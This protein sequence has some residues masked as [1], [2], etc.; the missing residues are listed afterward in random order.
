MTLLLAAA[1]AAALLAMSPVPS[2]GAGDEDVFQ[3][4]AYPNMFVVLERGASMTVNDNISVSDVDG[5]SSVNRY[6]LAL[7]VLFRVLNA[8][9]SQ[10][11]GHS[12]PPDRNLV[13][14]YSS[15]ID[16]DD[17]FFLSQ[18]VGFLSFDY[19][20]HSNSSVTAP[21]G[22]PFQVYAPG[23]P[24]NL[25]PYRNDNV[26]ASWQYRDLWDNIY[27]LGGP[28]TSGATIPIPWDNVRAC[29]S[30][31][32]S[33]DPD[34]CR[35]KV[36]VLIVT[37]EAFDTTG[38]WKTNLI[39]NTF[40]PFLLIVG[41][42]HRQDLRDLIRAASDIPDGRIAF[43]AGDADIENSTIFANLVAQ[44]Q[45]ST[46]EFVAPVVPAVRSTE[47]NRL[48]VA[49]FTPSTG[50]GE[51]RAFWPGHLVS[52]NLNTDGSIPSP[53]VANWDAA[54]R[55]NSRIAAR[56]IYTYE[57]SSG[58]RHEFHTVSTV[59]GSPPLVTRQM[60]GVTTDADR[61]IVVDSVRDLGLGDIFHS[62]PVLVGA[63][64]RFASDPRGLVARQTFVDTYSERKRILVAG[65]N[66]GMFH[67]F[68]AGNWNMSATPAGYDAGTGDEEWAYIPGFLVE[69]VKGFAP[70]PLGTPS[71]HNYY[72]DAP[73]TVTDIWV[74]SDTDITNAKRAEEWHT[75]AIGGA[76]RGGKGF[77]ALDITDPASSNYPAVLWE[78][79]SADSPYLGETWS[80]PAVG[81]LLIT[82]QITGTDVFYDKWVAL[83]GAG[84]A[85][86]SGR[87]QITSGVD[88][89]GGSVSG[90]T[91]TVDQDVGLAPASGG[92]TLT[93]GNRSVS[94]TYTSRSGNSFDN[95]T[96][97]AT[98]ASNKIVYPALESYVSWSATGSEGKA[99]LVL[100]AFTGSILQTLTHSSMGPVASSPTILNDEAG[101]IERGYI[102]D[103]QGNLWRVTVDNTGTFSLGGAP[104]ISITGSG[105]SNRIYTKPAVARGAGSYPYPW[106]YFGTGDRDAPMDTTSQGAIFGVFD[107]QFFTRRGTMTT[108]TISDTTDLTANST[109]LSSPDDQS[110]HLTVG[111][112]KKGWYA[113]LPNP[114]EK[115]L[116]S[117][118]A[119]FNGNLFFTT[120]Q[121]L[122]GN[123]SVGGTARVY[124]FRV[125]G[126]DDALGAF[127]LYSS[128]TSATPDTR[129]IAFENVGIP[130]APIVS[131][132]SGG[133]TNLYFGTT[134]S[135]VRSL[136]IPSPA[137]TKT[138]KYW[139]EVQ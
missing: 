56:R 12:T 65:A 100:D 131:V 39:D 8:D 74:D 11:G 105:Y 10:I 64:S 40:N 38:N 53:V 66:D 16:I 109:L 36:T 134:G 6:D 81:K 18:R 77:F 106:V 70:T 45:A 26:S 63:P 48:F 104:F 75:V 42:A 35:P 73:V 122:A 92:I 116:T 68:N 83:V 111:V 137:A 67:A 79:T 72:V 60:L 89:T 1:C 101:Y 102:G 55:L 94:G 15:L 33:G 107:S 78:K 17:E 85:A 91:I 124:G 121:P 108:S 47:N 24:P 54:E 34:A 123:C 30:T 7:K 29:F 80:V 115:A 31:A 61:N 49:S 2:R 50:S 127:A 5:N 98:G 20:V 37:P 99:I 44:L 23:N 132:G 103:L 41:S 19:A 93:K 3:Y 87:A 133:A 21:G 138:L 112:G 76:G 136:K 119:V 139:R 25:P 32:A 51:A 96:L 129:V 114:G 62:T 22:A 69:K 95:V 135:T 43:F 130:S 58:Q 117:P 88:L 71:I 4:R 125:I 118:P 28:L 82:Q 113:V 59:P 46:F 13:D 14:N 57:R 126:I 9:G 128:S 52:F 86:V 120:F 84:K 110:V 27:A 97:T 90:V